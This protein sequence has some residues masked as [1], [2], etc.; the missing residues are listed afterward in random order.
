MGYTM[1]ICHIVSETTDCKTYTTKRLQLFN[2]FLGKHYIYITHV[3][4]FAE[5]NQ[6]LIFNCLLVHGIID[7][8]CHQRHHG[9]RRIHC[10]G[11][12]RWS[13]IETCSEMPILM[14]LEGEHVN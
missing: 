2:S 11:K 8:C 5:I 4:K 9:L 10:F 1:C 6:R 14:L 3:C 7:A 12:L 13:P